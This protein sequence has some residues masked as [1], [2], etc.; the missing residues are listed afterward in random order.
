MPKHLLYTCVMYW[1]DW[2][3]FNLDTSS[4][5]SEGE[6][7]STAARE[8]CAETRI[9]N[10]QGQANGRFNVNTTH[11]YESLQQNVKHLPLL[12]VLWNAERN[13]GNGTVTAFQFMAE[14]RVLDALCQEQ[15][16]NKQQ[17][18]KRTIRVKAAR[19]FAHTSSCLLSGQ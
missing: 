11:L 12:P 10:R 7:A 15:K 6:P 9:L 4:T 18:V 19:S 3:T 1:M 16:L 2:M 5:S 8:N 17:Q 13:S 14:Y